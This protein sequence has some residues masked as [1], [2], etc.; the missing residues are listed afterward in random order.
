MKSFVIFTPKRLTE[1]DS[2]NDVNEKP[3][4]ILLTSSLL[5]DRVFLYTNLLKSLEEFGN[6]I[7]WATSK[8]NNQNSSIWNDVKGEVESFPEIR[9][10][11]EVPHNYMTAF[12]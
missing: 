7:I 5:V 12:E 9:P 10:F 6:V 4:I 8:E 2:K 11:M 1:F 3:K